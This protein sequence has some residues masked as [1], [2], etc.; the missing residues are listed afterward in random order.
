[1]EKEIRVIDEAKGILRITTISERWYARPST[2]KETGLPIYEYF[3][4]STWI[5]GYYPKG[6]PFYRWLAEH[7]WDESQ[8]IKQAAGDRGSRVHRA[9]ERLE[10]EGQLPINTVLINPETNEAEGMGQE[11]LDAVLSFSRWHNE[12]KPQLLANEMT[13]FGKD[14]AGTLDRIYRIA[15]Q[16]YIV[17][18]K[19]SK[20]IWEEH[21]L[22]I[23]SYSEAEID[24]KSL[25]ITGEEWKNRKLA[26]LQLGYPLNK[27]GFKFT[28]VENKYD[29]FVMARRIW[30]NENPKAKPRQRDYPLIIK[31]NGGQEN[32]SEP[33]TELG[34]KE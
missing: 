19:T 29:L 4:S 25:K 20:Y 16:V 2:D 33:I 12:N 9:T 7:G 6:I 10:K 28:E 14:Y 26:I 15:G 17:D 1:M 23:S 11:E 21:K 8:A 18:I 13:V 32:G 31:L 24:Y 3:P 30:E 22:Q 27:A 34:E 5:A